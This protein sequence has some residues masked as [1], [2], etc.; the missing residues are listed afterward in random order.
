MIIYTS[1]NRCPI[2]G[3]EVKYTLGTARDYKYQH[4]QIFYCSYT[5]YR[6]AT[7]HKY[8]KF[9]RYYSKYTIDQIATWNSPK[10]IKLFGDAYYDIE[11]VLKYLNMYNIFNHPDILIPL[12]KAT[13]SNKWTELYDI[14]T[15]RTDTH[16]S[17]KN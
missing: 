17:S 12:K 3:S 4:A 14:I 6:I 10:W 2:C 1:P 5:C 15:E 7:D 13:K 9:W 8:D 16:Q 11:L